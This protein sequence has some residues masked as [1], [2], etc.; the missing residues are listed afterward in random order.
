MA[1]IVAGELDIEVKAGA[2]PR[3]LQIATNPLVCVS[4]LGNRFEKE[5]VS[6][7]VLIEIGLPVARVNRSTTRN[8][9]VDP[10]PI[11]DLTNQ[12]LELL[13]AAEANQPGYWYLLPVRAMYARDANGD[14]TRSTIEI[15][16]RHYNEWKM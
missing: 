16:A 7:G 12:V 3:G 5:Q 1:A 6:R 15:E 13:R 11:E 14:V 8:L 9:I 10:E 2:M 4:V